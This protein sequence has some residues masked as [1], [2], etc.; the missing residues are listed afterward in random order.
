MPLVTPWVVVLL[1][2]L[3]GLFILVGLQKR[4]ILRN[5]LKLLTYVR[6]LKPQRYRR[7]THLH[8]APVS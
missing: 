5:Q 4:E 1:A 2:T 3:I 6:G 8:P 7:T